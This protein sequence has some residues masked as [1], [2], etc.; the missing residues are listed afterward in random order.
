MKHSGSL[1]LHLLF[2]GAELNRF[3][4]LAQP[5]WEGLFLI[6]GC[7]AA[8]LRKETRWLIEYAEE[9]PH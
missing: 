6:R 5:T 4:P 8:W 9:V 3:N 7:P 2:F 1:G